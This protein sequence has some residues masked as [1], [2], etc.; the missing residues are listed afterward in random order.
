M[1]IIYTIMTA[2]FS[3]AYAFEPVSIDDFFKKYPNE[4]PIQPTIQNN[5]SYNSNYKSSPHKNTKTE[6]IDQDIPITAMTYPKVSV[7]LLDRI[8]GRSQVTKFSIGE[9]KALN[10]LFDVTISECLERKTEFGHITHSVTMKVFGLANSKIDTQ[11]TTLYDDI[12][13]IEMP[14]FR[15]FQHPTYDIKPVKCFG[16]PQEVTE[17]I[18]R[19]EP[20]VNPEPQ[21]E[22]L[23]PSEPP[24][25]A[26]SKS[27]EPSESS[28]PLELLEKTPV[29]P[30]ASKE[31]SE[32]AIED[33]IND[34][35]KNTNPVP[36]PPNSEFI[37]VPVPVE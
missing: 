27:L 20:I 36:L 15:G 2:S 29:V 10:S 33:I 6:F 17:T 12:F 23:L 19:D 4:R 24:S 35:P 34:T 3:G 26:P 5:K 11:K 25:S 9:T 14:G 18:T 8:S 30:N 21:D 22:N 32:E 37:P 31:S 16:T 28:K 7:L 1:G 13:Y